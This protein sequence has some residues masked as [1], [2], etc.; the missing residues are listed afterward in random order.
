MITDTHKTATRP[1]FGEIAA[2]RNDKQLFVNKTKFIEAFQRF[3]DQDS[4]PKL[5]AKVVDLESNLLSVKTDKIGVLNINGNGD[6]IKISQ[7]P[8]LKGLL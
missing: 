7:F 6:T 5:R 3:K 1:L 4:L 2:N 8:I